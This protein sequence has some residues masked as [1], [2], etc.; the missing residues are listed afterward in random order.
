MA[1]IIA[2][3]SGNFNDTNTWMDGVVPTSADDVY[4]NGFTITLN[5]NA[6]VNSL[7]NTVS[8][9]YVPVCATPIMTSNTAPSGTV[10]GSTTSS[11]ALW[12]IFDQTLGIGV[13]STTTNTLLVQ[14]QYPTGKIIVRYAIYTGVT[15]GRQ[16]ATW[17][18]DGSN[19]GTTWTTLHSVTGASL[20]L[21]SWYNYTFTNT[22]SYTYYRM[23]VTAAIVSSVVQL[24]ELQMTESSSAAS[25]GAVGGSFVLPDGVTFTSTNTIYVGNTTPVVSYSGTTSASLYITNSLIIQEI[26]NSILIDH[27]NTGHLYFYGN[28]TSTFL[29]A[30]TISPNMTG[31]R[32]TSSG[33]LTVNG[34]IT[35][36]TDASSNGKGSRCIYVTGTN[37]TIN[38]NG[39]ISGLNMTSSSSSA[40]TPHYGIFLQGTNT[41]VNV[42]G[43]ITGGSVSAGTISGVSVIGIFGVNGNVTVVG[44]VTGGFH[45]TSS[46]RAEAISL[47]G[48]SVTVNGDVTGGTSSNAIGLRCSGTINITGAVISQAAFAVWN[49]GNTNITVTGNVTSNA[50]IGISSAGTSS[51]NNISG[52]VTAVGAAPGLYASSTSTN[53]I[54]GNLVNGS[55]GAMAF[56][57][58]K[59]Y[60]STSGS[61]TWTFYNPSAATKI[62][63]T[64]DL[65]SPAGSQ[66][67]VTDVRSGTTYALGT[68]TGTCAIPPRNSVTAG[69]PVDNGVGTALLTLSTLQTYAQA[70]WNL[71]TSAI[72]TSGSIG[73]R[74]KEASTVAITGQQIAGFDI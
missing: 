57:G 20:A 10:T 31:I 38:F 56:W 11:G 21:S 3:Q 68:L 41:T 25:G 45:G 1:Q 9:L 73:E 32:I 48:S 66:P 7:R 46:S 4:A 2:K 15:S 62:L 34:S 39:N 71:Q 28:I 70:V 35:G 58:Q 12:N 52:N 23:N 5:T 72:T 65:V 74:L 14:Y 53:I 49:E 69:V 29:G 37:S 47:T 44:N 42:T 50:T 26:S 19:D 17:T 22:T 24:A 54:T 67:A 6:T 8:T 13:T 51:T 55:S 43:N 33:T 16:P 60:L 64:G 63:Y 61:R 27:T 40:T 18:F 59:L 36:M 30:A